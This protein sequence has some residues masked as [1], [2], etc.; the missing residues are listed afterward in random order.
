MAYVT[1]ARRAEGRE[2]SKGSRFEAVAAPA[3]TLEQARALLAA[4]RE[5]DPGATHHVS[6]WRLG[7]SV[8]FDD[9]GEPGGT[10][11]RPVLEVLDKRGLD[12]VAVV[13]TRHFGGR[14]LGAGGLVRAYTAAAARALDAA[15]TREVPDRLRALVRA[16]FAHL[17]E[18]HRALGAW[19]ELQVL[20]PTY[21][22]EGVIL[23]VRLRADAHEALERALADATRGA[24]RLSDVR[25]E[26]EGDPRP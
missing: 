26:A 20:E 6:A 25:P 18:V 11:G 21:D 5:A 16:P 4:R 15:G 23:P 1:V 14:K 22:A 9:D 2:E 3:G 8:H 19:P 17:D 13:V 24:A 7:T 12:R 10:A